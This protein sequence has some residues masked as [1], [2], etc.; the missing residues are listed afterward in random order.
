MF[1]ILSLFFLLAFVIIKSNTGGSSVIIGTPA[2]KF[3]YNIFNA[4]S[5]PTDRTEVL[6]TS[7]IAHPS[8]QKR[9]FAEHPY[10]CNHLII[11]R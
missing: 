9:T 5:F 10:N 11:N 4:K 6:A 8:V 1:S 3:P 2:A 7:V